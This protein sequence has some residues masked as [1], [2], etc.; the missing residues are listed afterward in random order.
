M[1]QERWYID[2][3]TPFGPPKSDL[4]DV[5]VTKHLAAIESYPVSTKGAK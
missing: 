1:G 3:H 2:Y 4:T 5:E